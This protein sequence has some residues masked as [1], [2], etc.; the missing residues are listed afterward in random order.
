MVFRHVVTI[1]EENYGD[2]LLHSFCKAIEVSV[3]EKSQLLS[4]NGSL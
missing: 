3:C 2:N 1:L 4:M